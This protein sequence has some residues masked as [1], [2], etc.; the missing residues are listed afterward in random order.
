MDFIFRYFIICYSYSDYHLLCVGRCLYA[1]FYVDIKSMWHPLIQDCYSFAFAILAKI[2]VIRSF[3]CKKWLLTHIVYTAFGLDKLLF[4]CFNHHYKLW[5]EEVNQ[6]FTYRDWP[7]GERRKKESG[8]I[9]P[10][11][12]HW[13]RCLVGCDGRLPLESQGIDCCT[14]LRQIYSVN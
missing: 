13:K 10:G 8:W 14:R 1:H 7:V 3:F 2:F 9:H 12:S 6:R 5:K 11:V 4:L